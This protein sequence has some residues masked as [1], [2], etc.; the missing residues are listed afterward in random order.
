MANSDLQTTI[1]IPTYNRN[2]LLVKVLPSY[3]RQKYVEEIIIVDDGSSLEIGTYLNSKQIFNDKIKII[4]HNRSLG[5]CA[6]RNTGI[7]NTKTPWIF[8]GEDDL[9]LSDNHI[10]TLH[11]QRKKLGADLICG[12][13]IQQE[14]EESISNIQNNSY[15]HNIKPIFNERLITINNNC[16]T[17]PT[18]LP[19]A[20]AIF[21]VPTSIIK[22][23][24]F[25]TRIGGPSFL[26]EDQELQLTLRKAGYKLFAI[27]DAIAFH[28]LKSKGYGSGTRL[29]QSMAIDIASATIN[30][31]LVINEH[32]S[33]IASFFGMMPKK[34]ML[35]RVVFWTILIEI[36]R[37]MQ[38]KSRILNSIIHYLRQILNKL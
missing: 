31:W 33:S 16:I 37:R 30:S 12:N 10:A 3:L 32:Y 15:C 21:L 38:A 27:P 19:F 26:R 11:C 13:L 1:V 34:R 29:N 8:F 7:I 6:A 22:Q 35:R 2:K 28:L 24:L 17:K 23:Y 36:K 20:H 5:S 25:S 14:K 9:I 4:R 18:E